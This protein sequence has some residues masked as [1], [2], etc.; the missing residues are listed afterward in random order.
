MR[1]V[2]EAAGGSGDPSAPAGA[3]E[4]S[5]R[6]AFSRRDL[7]KGGAAAGTLGTL[8]LLDAEGAGKKKRRNKAAGGEGAGKA[9]AEEQ[10]PNLP[11]ICGPGPVKIRFR[12]NGEF[13]DLAV[14]PRETLLEVLRDRLGLYGTKEVCDRGSCGACTVLVDGSPIHACGTLALS[15]HRRQVNTVEGL[16]QARRGGRPHPLA[17]AFV[18]AGALQ[19]GFCTPG[20]LMASQALLTRNAA[21]SEADVDQAL[22]GN[23]CRCGCYPAIRQAV[24]ATASLGPV[25][26]GVEVPEPGARF[27]LSA[28]EMPPSEVPPPEPPPRG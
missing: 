19:C 8:G 7:L 20:F 12:V 6:S 5:P 28:P 18:A 4:A 22:C 14:E 2:D 9:P 11:E 16:A 26:D 15:V 3:G 27:P 10:A 1:L 24:L 25:T 23:L 13:R 17:E 21:P